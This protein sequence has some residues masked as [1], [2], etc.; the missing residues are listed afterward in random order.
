MM[1]FTDAPE[2][3]DA[4]AAVACAVTVTAAPLHGP[5]QTPGGLPAVTSSTLSTWV[6]N[7]SPGLS[8]FL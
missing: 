8:N 5:L 1:Q 4:G 6:C 3:P 2:F 7:H